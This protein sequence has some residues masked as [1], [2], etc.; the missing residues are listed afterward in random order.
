MQTSSPVP[1]PAKINLFFEVLGKRDD[2]FHEIVSVALPVRLFDRLTLEAADDGKITFQCTGQSADVPADETNIVVKTLEKLRQRY[3]V[4]CGAS[5][6]LQ[7]QIP[8]Q[9]G[10]GG[11]SSDAAAAASAA[12]KAWQL[13]VTKI[14]LAALLAEI[15]SDCPLFLYD[16]ASISTGR[17]ETVQPLPAAA[18]LWFVIWKPAQ[19]LSTAAVYKE[20]MPLHDGHF[21]KPDALITALASG[22]ADAVG[23]ELFNR[24]EV[25]ARKL[26]TG[27]DTAFD[28]VRRK[29]TEAGCIAVQLCGSGAS[30]FGLCYNQRHAEETASKLSPGGQVFAVCSGGSTR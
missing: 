13:N 9:A 27:F 1:A 19:G 6:H 30:F 8:S 20:C 3:G 12:V 16:T 24:L 29:L 25:P 7:K 21:R 11:G 4:R 17:G 22:N 18:P 10:L 28:D 5:V 2:G 14:E 23:R 26:W 15:G